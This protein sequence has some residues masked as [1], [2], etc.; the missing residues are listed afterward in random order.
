MAGSVDYI[1]MGGMFTIVKVPEQ[2][3]ADGSDPG[4]YKSPPGTLA[5]LAPADDLKRDGIELPKDLPKTALIRTPPKGE[6]W[7]GPVPPTKT[8]LLARNEVTARIKV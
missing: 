5:E 4:W 6:V 7:C 8:P 2:L 1:A 3:P